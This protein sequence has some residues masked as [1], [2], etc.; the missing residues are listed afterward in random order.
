MRSTKALRDYFAATESQPTP[1]TLTVYNV[2]CIVRLNSFSRHITKLHA[3]SQSTQNCTRR[4]A[5][6]ECQ[7]Q[8]AFLYTR[9]IQQYT[10]T[11]YTVYYTVQT[12]SIHCIS[13]CMSVCPNFFFIELSTAC[14]FPIQ[15]G[16]CL[17]MLM[18][19]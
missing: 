12:Y 2:N 6:R 15:H 17:V 3:T 7:L 9:Y 10:V 14:I 4:G 5:R 1:V 19:R 18:A 8:I 11:V 13:D 16:I